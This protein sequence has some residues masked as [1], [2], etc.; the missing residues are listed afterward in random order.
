MPAC[1]W[2]AAAAKRKSPVGCRRL[3]AVRPRSASP[4]PSRGAGAHPKHLKTWAR[5]DGDDYL[6]SGEKTYLTNGPLAGLF[7]VLAIT[8]EEAGR[9]QF[10][11]F[12][13]P[14]ESPG[15]RQVPGVEI[16]FLH[17]APHCGIVLENCR[18]PAA[19]LLGPEGDAFER[20]SL[21]MRAL[22]D[23]LA[24]ASTAGALA[25]ELGCLARAAADNNDREL[26]AG[27]GQMSTLAAALDQLAFDLAARLDRPAVDTDSLN[28]LSDGFR[29]IARHLQKQMDG[30]IKAHQIVPGT[31]YDAMRHDIVKSQGIARSAH[32]AKSVKYGQAFIAESTNS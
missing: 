5:R 18:L 7:I 6:I 4:F 11:G 3:P 22:E 27:L 29:Q 2:P 9:K 25:Y 17:P 21:N 14:R 24:T 20:I 26:I 23:A 10:S 1:T 28:R 19:N 13:V 12:L 32:Q 15:L 30:F 16:D 31:G 8:G